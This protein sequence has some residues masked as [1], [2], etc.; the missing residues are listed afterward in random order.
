MTDNYRQHYGSCANISEPLLHTGDKWD[1]PKWY[2]NYIRGVDDKK[3]P[4]PARKLLAYLSDGKWNQKVGLAGVG[5]GSLEAC[6]ELELIEDHPFKKTED[7]KGHCI[8][9]RITLRGK[10]ALKTQ[11][12]P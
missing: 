9:F 5:V 10:E 12:L 11:E 7:G 3:L 2:I 6:V 4:T 8:E 1:Y